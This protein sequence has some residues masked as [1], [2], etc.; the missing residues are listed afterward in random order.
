MKK[1]YLDLCKKEIQILLDKNLIRKN[2]SLWCCTTFYVSKKAE[3]E[4]GILR[5]IINYNPHN[6]VLKWIRYPIPNKK[7]LLD[8]LNFASVFSKF[9]FKFGYWRVQINEA[10]RY[11]T[12]FVL[13]FGHYECNVMSFR[14]KNAY[15]EFQN[16]MND[17]FY[18]YSDFSIIY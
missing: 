4:R 14:L 5:H 6:S 17:I 10:D 3:Q 16:I 13:S 15:L 11:K 12:S 2:T 18:P 8:R 7:A 9:D 1:N